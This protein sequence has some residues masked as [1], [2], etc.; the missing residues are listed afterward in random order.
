LIINGAIRGTVIKMTLHF[1]GTNYYS[2]QAQ[3]QRHTG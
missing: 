1:S 3:Q 2:F